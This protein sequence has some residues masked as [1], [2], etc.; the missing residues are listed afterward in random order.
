MLQSEIDKEKSLKNG[1]FIMKM[2]FFL[3][4]YTKVFVFSLFLQ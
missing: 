1:I 4:I 2:P 3:W